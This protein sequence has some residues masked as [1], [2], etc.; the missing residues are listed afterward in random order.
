M[1]GGDLDAGHR[2]PPLE[3][4]HGVLEGGVEADLGGPRVEGELGPHQGGVGAGRRA[5]AGQGADQHGGEGVADVDPGEL[6]VVREGG[7]PVPGGLGLGDPQLGPVVGAVP[8]VLG[9]GDAVARGHEVEL[10]G[11][12][13]LLG[14]QAVGVEHL[15]REQPGDG[16]EADVGVG[17]DVE[18]TV[19]GAHVVDEA[20]GPDGAPGPVGEGA[21]HRELA[22]G[23]LPAGGDLD[24]GLV[25]RGLGVRAEVLAAHRAAHR[26]EPTAARVWWGRR[27]R[28]PL[29]CRRRGRRPARRSRPGHR[30]CPSGTGTR[31]RPP[32]R[33]PWPGAPP[34]RRPGRRPAPRRRPR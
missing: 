34:P 6:G 32:G 10:A 18:P 23:G 2:G 30:P 17:A 1:P 3:D 13:G 31:A 7:R 24:L 21:P 29:R 20:P 4:H 22:D 8:A 12:D 9:V 19:G 28:V 26:R 15:A 5:G 25:G 27:H 16:L 33:R 14:A 11:A